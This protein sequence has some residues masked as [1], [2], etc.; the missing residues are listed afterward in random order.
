MMVA[1]F[2]YDAAADLYFG[3]HGV[4]PRKSPAYRRFARASAALQFAVE[5]LTSKQL[6]YAL[7]EVDEARFTAAEIRLLY[8]SADYPL[9]R[10]STP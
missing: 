5:Q 1:M 3:R 7:L 9:A 4:H 2:D 6:D 10:K 8:A